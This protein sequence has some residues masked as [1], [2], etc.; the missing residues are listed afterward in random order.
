MSGG[1]PGSTAL[2]DDAWREVIDAVA[3]PAA[4]PAAATPRRGRPGW[5]C[6]TTPSGST[7]LGAATTA[8]ALLHRR[9]RSA[10]WCTPTAR[11]RGSAARCSR[12]ALAGDDARADA[13]G[14]TAT[15][16]R[17][18]ALAARHG[19]RPGARAVGDAAAG[20]ACRCREL[21]VPRRASRCAGTA[22]GDEDER[23]R[24][25][26]RRRSPHHPEQGAMDAAEPGRADGRAVVR[27]G[28]AARGGRRRRG[29]SAST[30]PSS[31]R[32]SSARCTS[33]AI[34]PA[35]QG[36]GLGK[37]L[38]L[39]GPAPPRRPRASTRCC[40]TSSPTTR[41]RSRSTPGSASP[42][43]PRDTHVMYRRG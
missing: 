16:R 27:P 37:V 40:S 17:R 28:R 9:R 26:T 8:F 15:T 23:A 24:G 29:C 22:T 39:A 10:S 21:V 33:S 25:S 36:R 4:R 7:S 1:R 5:R 35:A 13:P 31:T 42:T 12:D 3:R 34:D 43:R 14:R 19:L 41:P 18:R 30:G 20:A 32:P 6:A 2:A 11:G 38:T